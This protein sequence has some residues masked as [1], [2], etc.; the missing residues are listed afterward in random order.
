MLRDISVLHQ[1]QGGLPITSH[2][3][4]DLSRSQH[5]P[6]SAASLKS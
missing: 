6:R 4:S 5:R 3:R 1:V 2:G